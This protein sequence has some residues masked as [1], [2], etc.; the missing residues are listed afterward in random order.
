[1]AWT[2]ITR[3]KYQRDRRRY[4]SDTADAEWALIEPHMAPPAPR[5]RS[6]QLSGRNFMNNLICWVV[7]CRPGTSVLV[8]VVGNRY[9]PHTPRRADGAKARVAVGNCAE[10]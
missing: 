10:G 3:A 5:G 9:C 4:A 8:L 6:R 2:E 7:T 1:M